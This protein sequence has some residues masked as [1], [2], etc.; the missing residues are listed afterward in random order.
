MKK[1]LVVNGP[2]LSM[3]G[4]REPEIYGKKTLDDINS[5]LLEKAE[6]LGLEIYFFQSDSEGEIVS[7]LNQEFQKIDGLIINAA[8]YTHTSIAI[9]DAVS[10]HKIPVCEVHLSNIYKR[11]AMRHKSYLS[12]I[13]DGV[14]CGLGDMGYT[15]A[16]QALAKLV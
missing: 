1:I 4:K 16:L 11:E 2:N 8:A 10:M 3:L 5:D 9:R 7:K 15:F 12:D 6:E 13:A 14:I